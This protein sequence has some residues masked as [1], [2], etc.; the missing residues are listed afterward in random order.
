MNFDRLEQII[1]GSASVEI[2]VDGSTKEMFEA[3]RVGGNFERTMDRLNTVRRLRQIHTD[4]PHSSWT[5]NFV[6]LTLNIHELPDVIRIAKRYEIECVKVLDY[7]YNFREYDKHSLRNDVALGR[8]W[9]AEA[10]GVADELGIVLTL[11]PLHEEETIPTADISLWAKIKRAGRLFPVR[12]RFP[13]RCADPWMK[14]YVNDNGSVTACCL[15]TK[16]LGSLRTSSFDKIWN[17]WRYRFLRW[18]ID[19]PLPPLMCRNCHMNLGVNSG[20]AGNVMA[21]E[22]LI[23]KGLYQFE[24]RLAQAI[25]K[26]Q[27]AWKRFSRRPRPNPNYWRGKPI[28]EKNRPG[29]VEHSAP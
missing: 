28:S 5:L 13:Q 6:A 14:T 8:R 4:K 22:G 7:H 29:V 19:T 11:P 23:I 9:F 25:G 15:A 20:N 10:Q 2:S 16:S 24:I 26:V 27:Q 21:K 18:R 12:N 17:G 3:I 1:H